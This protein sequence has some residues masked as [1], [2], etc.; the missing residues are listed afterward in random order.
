M[1]IDTS[2]EQGQGSRPEAD[3]P[4]QAKAPAKPAEP[5]SPEKTTDVHGDPET[6]V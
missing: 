2:G 3:G 4:D 5:S 6:P 1:A